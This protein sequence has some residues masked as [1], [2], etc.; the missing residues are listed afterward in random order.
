LTANPAIRQQF[1]QVASGLESEK[2][3]DYTFKNGFVINADTFAAF[4]Q[5]Y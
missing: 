3:A 5:K 2:L 4:M 1:I